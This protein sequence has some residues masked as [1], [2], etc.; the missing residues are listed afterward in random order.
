MDARSKFEW[1]VVRTDAGSEA[2]V[3]D[4]IQR[5][6][7][8]S[9]SPS[10]TLKGSKLRAVFPRYAFAQFDFF[11][12]DWPKI[13]DQRGVVRLMPLHQERPIPL[14]TEFVRDCAQRDAQGEFEVRGSRLA[15]K[16]LKG[17]KMPLPGGVVNGTFVESTDKGAVM[18][19]VMF[20]KSRRVTVP[21]GKL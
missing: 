9:Y 8:P 6:G 5:L 10:F 20:G 7:F 3:V 12:D 15:L 17:D 19:V 2:K 13:N 18:D 21:F 14:P 4:G 16:Y 1:F 11:E